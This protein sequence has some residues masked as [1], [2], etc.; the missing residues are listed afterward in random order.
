MI[1]FEIFYKI[2]GIVIAL[3]LPLLP[4]SLV[5][6]YIL[7]ELKEKKILFLIFGLIIGHALLSSIVYILWMSGFK[8]NFLLFSLVF[9]LLTL[10]LYFLGKIFLLNSQTYSQ[11]LRSDD[12]NESKVQN[13][14]VKKQKGLNHYIFILLVAISVIYFLMIGITSFTEEVSDWPGIGIWGLKAKIIYFS[15]T[16]SDLLTNKEIAY[17]HPE[18]PLGYALMITWYSHL[19]GDFDNYLIKTIPLFWGG[20]AF[21]TIYQIGNNVSGRK[22]I[23]LL[24]A[25]FVAS[26][27]TYFNCCIKMYSEMILI[28]SVLAGFYCL[29]KF[30]QI[31][32]NLR[33]SQKLRFLIMG[34]ILLICSTW[35]KNEGMLYLIVAILGVM[36]FGFRDIRKTCKSNWKITIYLLCTTIVLILLP[37]IITKIQYGL[38]ARDFSFS[39]GIFFSLTPYSPEWKKM[40]IHILGRFHQEYFF[41]KYNIGI[42]CSFILISTLIFIRKDF[43]KLSVIKQHFIQNLHIYFIFCFNNASMV[44][45]TSS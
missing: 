44:A 40:I 23:A 34:F 6:E 42:C 45:S 28:S 36:I 9:I 4:G 29:T 8:I 5:V 43:Y 10:S 7:P 30:M 26:S 1:I 16:C 37:W 2:V 22:N 18:Y 41:N 33:R 14:T 17:S 39:K 3:L 20:I 13:K 38:H 24:F 25:L 11:F 27:T 21:L 31:P 19:I 15:G 32:N 35:Y 12:F